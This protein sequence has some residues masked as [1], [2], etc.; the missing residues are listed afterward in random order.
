VKKPAVRAS[1]A[2]RLSL[3]PL[4]VFDLT[5]AARLPIPLKTRKSQVLLA[6]LALAGPNPH[7]RSK[8]IDLL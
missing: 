7:P 8:L 1:G 2:S 6:W 4:R 3:K 5:S